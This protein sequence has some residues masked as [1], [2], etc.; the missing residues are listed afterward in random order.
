MHVNINQ[1]KKCK[2]N[3]SYENTAFL[4]KKFLITVPSELNKNVAMGLYIPSGHK[5]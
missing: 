1:I 4:L 3:V 2:S 5:Y